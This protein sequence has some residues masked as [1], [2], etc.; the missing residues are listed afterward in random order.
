MQR[1][2]A[3]RCH[4]SGEREG[5]GSGSE[6]STPAARPIKSAPIHRPVRSH[7]HI[8]EHPILGDPRHRPHGSSCASFGGTSSGPGELKHAHGLTWDPLGRLWFPEHQRNRQSLGI[9]HSCGDGPRSAHAT[10]PGDATG[11]ALQIVPA[12]AVR[13]RARIDHR[14]QEGPRLGLGPSHHAPLNRVTIQSCLRT[15]SAASRPS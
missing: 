9:Q 1:V 15:G 12:P 7:F 10:D 5:D 4:H 8:V 13:P 11:Q 2:K 14:K 3:G 6:P